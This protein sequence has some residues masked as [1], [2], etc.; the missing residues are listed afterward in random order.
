MK[1]M[2][3]IQKVTIRR[4]LD[5]NPDTSYLGEYS[6][7]R[8]SEFSIDRAEDSGERE[9]D[10]TLGT[11]GHNEYRWFNPGSVEKFDPLATWIPTDLEGSARQVYWYQAMKQNAIQDFERMESLQNQNWY[12]LGIRAEAEIQVEGISQ[13]IS[14]G[15]LWGIESDSDREYLEEI[16]RDELADLKGILKGLGFGSRAISQAFKEIQHKDGE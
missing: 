11:L 6:N 3:R 2:K 15:G 10:C 4:I 13:D 8:E 1:T 14:S 5:T 7:K 9:C 12:Y 16:E